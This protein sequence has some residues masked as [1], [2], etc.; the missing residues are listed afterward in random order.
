MRLYIYAAGDEK[1]LGAHDKDGNRTDKFRAVNTVVLP[2]GDLSE[3]HSGLS[4]LVREGKT[5]R[6]VL[7]STHGS[8]GYLK[9]GA[10][11][12]TSRVLRE[13]FAGNGYERLFPQSAKMYFAGCNVAGDTECNGACPPGG[14]N[15]GWTFLETI[16]RVFLHGGGY[17]VGWTSYGYGLDWRPSRLL[18]TSHMVHFSGDVRHVLFLPGGVP[19]ERLSYDG[20]LWSGDGINQ[21][22]IGARL[23]SLVPPSV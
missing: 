1:L 14:V 3:L 5:F 12:L 10:Q 20:A 15:K 19:Y 7:W 9:F 23:Y 11:G 22:R 13:Q 2:A 8:P 21:A 4:R 6:H 18:Y 17:T 16:G